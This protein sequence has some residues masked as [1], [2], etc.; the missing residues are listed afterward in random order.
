MRC[1]V[2]GG[3]GH[4]GFN[5]VQ[6][7][8]ARGQRVRATV[9]SLAERAKTARLAALPG[10]E[11][12]EA[13]VRDEAQMRSA[14][15]GVDMLFH[16][17]AVYSLAEPGRDAEILAAATRGTEVSLRAAAAAGVQRVVMTSSV[18]T[19]PLT[20]PGAPPATEADWAT[21]LR[22]PYVRAKT[23]SERLAWRLADELGLSLATVLPAGIIGPGFAR[24]TPTLDIVQA[25]LMGEF[26]L[27]APAGNFSFVDVRDVAEAHLLAAERGA[28]GRFIVGYDVAPS[29]DRLVR[30]L[31]RIDRR[32]KPP[33]MVLPVFMAPLL[34]L[35]DRF[36]H[37]VFGTPRIA[38]PEGIASAV[39]GKVWN[40]SCARA[41]AE[42][43]WAARI[44]F[45][46]SLRD[47]V[48]ALRARSTAG[49]R[50]G[51]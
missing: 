39:S 45:E 26:R 37:A 7:L 6:A 11:L 27:G 17:A 23:E 25:C 18:V 46:Q 49:A 50:G 1:L 42:L 36:S 12:A 16:V 35:Y 8:L 9:R 4:L 28:R 10:L 13:D 32:V 15:D 47:T 14:L 20:A 38:T 43:G 30:T 29:F 24:N 3:N 44:P 33:L 21:D 34:P 5:L 41:K 31:A 48:A 51:D 22:V 19:L 40:Y 2:T